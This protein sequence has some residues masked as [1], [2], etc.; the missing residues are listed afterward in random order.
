[1]SGNIFTFW[2]FVPGLCWARYF[3][4]LFYVPV[5]AIIYLF[6]DYNKRVKKT[7]NIIAIGLIVL[8]CTN[9]IPNIVFSNKML[10]DKYSMIENELEQF[11]NITEEN[12]VVVG[13]NSGRF[14]GR[15]FTLEDMGITDYTFGEVDEN[16]VTGDIFPNYGLVYKIVE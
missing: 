16:E 11:K 14:S 4:A 10:T 3:G 6:L 5:V 1:M 8:L 12:D 7:D 9:M 2:N 15:I 13:Y